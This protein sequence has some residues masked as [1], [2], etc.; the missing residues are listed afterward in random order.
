MTI[1]QI[2]TPVVKP[3]GSFCYNPTMSLSDNDQQLIATAKATINTF[4]IPGGKIGYVGAALR[5]KEGAIYKGVSLHLV[6]G[7]GFCGEAN[8]I[9][10]ALTEAGPIQIDTIVSANPTGIISPCGRCRELMNVLADDSDET[11]VIVSENEKLQLKDLLPRPWKPTPD[12]EN[13]V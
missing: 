7:L 9:A 4:S 11:W 1:L 8:A 2:I 5:T 13:K 10:N 6:C 3:I 12:T